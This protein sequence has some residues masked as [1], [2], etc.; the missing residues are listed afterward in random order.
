MNMEGAADRAAFAK[1]GNCL[2][3]KCEYRS[4]SHGV[5]VG[6]TN[7]AQPHEQD[8]W[9]TL[10]TAY[11]TLYDNNIT[12]VILKWVPEPLFRCTGCLNCRDWNE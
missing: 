2:N 7:L 4:Q 5:E 9:T 1:N 12:C 3:K 10:L 6:R 11:Q 8:S